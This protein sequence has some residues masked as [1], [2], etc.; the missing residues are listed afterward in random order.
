M[1]INAIRG[2][3]VL[4]AIMGFF[5][6]LPALKLFALPENEYLSRARAIYLGCTYVL[7]SLAL[8]V[9]AFAAW[10]RPPFAWF[11]ALI[12]MFT[13]L[14]SP[15]WAPPRTSTAK[16]LNPKQFKRHVPLVIAARLLGVILLAGA[17]YRLDG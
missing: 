11:F 4:H 14:P 2:L 1:I 13:Y 5:V 9:C 10:H 12:S 3:G 17:A 8:T 7:A 15:G 16:A 6:L